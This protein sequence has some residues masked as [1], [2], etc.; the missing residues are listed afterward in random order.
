M[1]YDAIAQREAQNEYQSKL[2]QHA[3]KVRV[4]KALDQQIQSQNH[5]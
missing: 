3:Q 1:H 2:N 4:K 5:Q